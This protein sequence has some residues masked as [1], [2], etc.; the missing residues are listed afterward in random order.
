MRLH[1]NLKT[2]DLDRSR[3]FYTALFG[4]D[5][6]KV[7][8]DY[9][10]FQPEDV[11]VTLALMPGEP[12]TD[13]SVDH[14]GLRWGDTAEAQA[15]WER[16]RNAGLTPREEREVSCCHA[17]QDKAWVVDP[18]GRPWELYAVTDEQAVPVSR[19]SGC[20]A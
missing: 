1:L 11:P 16:V 5:P 4:A 9:L 19:P 7:R 20:C 10:R 15:A 14:L 2:R 12:G 3:A 18:D 17:V 8:D 13:G 6:D